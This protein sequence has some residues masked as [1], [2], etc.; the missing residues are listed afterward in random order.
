MRSL[1]ASLINEAFTP[2]RPNEMTAL[3]DE[4]PGTASIGLPPL[5]MMSSTVS[6]IPITLRIVFVVY[7]LF[8]VA[9]ISLFGD[10]AK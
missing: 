3:N 2:A 1:P 6:P 7:I 10:N 9:K 8:L 5:K 4:P